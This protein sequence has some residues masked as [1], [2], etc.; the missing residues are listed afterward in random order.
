M[1]SRRDEWVAA[2]IY[3]RLVNEALLAFDKVIGL[4][5]SEVALD[6]SLHKAPC[7]GE[8]TGKN[9]TDRGKGGWKWSI[10]TDL[11]GIPFGWTADGANRNDSVLLEPTLDDANAREWLSQVTTIWVVP[12]I[13]ATGKA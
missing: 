11:S 4:R 12:P 10:L 2:G 9:P 7:G 6:G 5:F 1:R 3:D 13:T 8:G